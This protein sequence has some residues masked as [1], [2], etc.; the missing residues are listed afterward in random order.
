VTRAGYAL[1]W[2]PDG[3][4]RQAVGCRVAQSDS[5]RTLTNSRSL[6]V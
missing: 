5:E 1:P 2:L 4:P 3:E 6:F